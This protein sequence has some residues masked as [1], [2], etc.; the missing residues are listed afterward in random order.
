MQDFEAWL[1]E[2]SIFPSETVIPASEWKCV[3]SDRKNEEIN[4]LYK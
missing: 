3:K 1:P 4:V 2:N